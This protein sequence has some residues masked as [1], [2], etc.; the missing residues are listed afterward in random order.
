[1]ATPESIGT[2]ACSNCAHEV[3][4]RKNRSGYA[5]YRCEACGVMVQHHIARESAKFIAAKVK[6]HDDKP[7]APTKPAA[8]N[9]PAP[10]A[11]PADKPAA[12]GFRTLL[13][14]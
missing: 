11:A 8:K 13:G 14:G 3:F 1:M 2:A 12:A 10:K 9:S 4:I 5:Y 7:E 6:L